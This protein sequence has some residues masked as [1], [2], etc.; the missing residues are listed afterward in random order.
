VRQLQQAW[1][2]LPWRCGVAAV[3]AASFSLGRVPAG[4]SRP[5]A[6]AV[7]ERVRTYLDTYER[8][9]GRLVADERFEQRIT[10]PG[11]AVD[12]N[13]RTLE[14]DFGFLPLPEALGWLGH[15][16]VRRIDGR[17]VGADIPRLDDVFRRP[18]LDVMAT[19]RRIAADNERFNLG[20]PRT[21]NTPTL[22]LELLHRRHARLFTVSD[23]GTGRRNDKVLAQLI[24]REQRPGAIIAHDRLRFV[25]TDVRA[26]VGRDDGV[27]WRAEVTLHP[28]AGINAERHRVEVDFADDASVALVVPVRLIEIFRIGGQGRGLATYTNY[29]RFQTSGRLVPPPGP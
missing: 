11:I 25:R 15:R 7:L 10:T 6:E 16:S 13:R 28:P 24:L 20:P 22:P 12:A 26:W 17:P 8:E 27:V 1:P 19:A 21:M 2:R 29:R 5:Q 9:L 23:H 18:G 14:S 3:L 4:Q